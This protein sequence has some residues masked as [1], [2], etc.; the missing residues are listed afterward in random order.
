MEPETALLQALH[1]DPADE[2]AWLALADCLEE[3]D[4]PYRA[5]VVRLGRTLRRLPLS[6]EREALETRLCA[7]LVGVDPCVPEVVSSVGMRLALIP[8]GVYAMGAPPGESQG[9]EERHPV[10][11]TRP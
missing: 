10:E 8:A 1:R 6:Q 3:N 7:L 2:T 4:Q 9:D 5:E 11:I